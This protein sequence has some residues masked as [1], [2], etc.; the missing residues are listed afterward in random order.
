MEGDTTPR[1][2]R[3]PGSWV[4]RE[5]VSAGKGAPGRTMVP[6]G[7]DPLTRTF[8]STSGTSSSSVEPTGSPTPVTGDVRATTVASEGTDWWPGMSGDSPGTPYNP[9]S[10]SFY[11]FFYSSSPS[12]GPVSSSVDSSRQVPGSRGRAEDRSGDLR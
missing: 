7:V 3:H 10:F 2:P 8:D 5:G 4:L 9:D 6:G 1:D 12:F 11:D